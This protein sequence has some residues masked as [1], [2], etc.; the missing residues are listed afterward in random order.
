MLDFYLI[1]DDQSKPSCPE[2][3]NLKY[4][5]GLDERTFR[6]LKA[7]GLIDGRFNYHTDFRWKSDLIKQKHHELTNHKNQNDTD[8]RRFFE[9]INK[10]QEINCGLIA[11]CD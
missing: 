1:D 8:L 6:N 7:K 10:A 2:D 5:G 9:L 3:M 11:Y 4:I